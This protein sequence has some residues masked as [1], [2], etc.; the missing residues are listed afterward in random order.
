MNVTSKT[1]EEKGIRANVYVNV[2][3]LDI[4]GNNKYANVFVNATSKIW[5]EMGMRANVYVDVT[6]KMWEGM[7]MTANVYLNVTYLDTIGNNK[8]TQM[9]I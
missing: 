1:W 5:E 4:I 2:A 3:Y 6:S 9:F 8:N 7:G